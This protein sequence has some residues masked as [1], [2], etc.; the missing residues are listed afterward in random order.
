M[1]LPPDMGTDVVKFNK[2]ATEIRVDH[3]AHALSA[4]VHYSEWIQ[5]PRN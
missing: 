2:E 3:L 4:I 5:K 1:V